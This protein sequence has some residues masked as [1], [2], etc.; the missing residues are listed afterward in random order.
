[1]MNA[2]FLTALL[3]VAF[4]TVSYAQMNFGIRAGAA[5]NDV[6]A[7]E[8]LDAITPEFKNVTTYNISL[9]SEYE[10]GDYFSIQPELSYNTK[11]FRIKETA[12]IELWN[13]PLPVGI[14]AVSKFSYLEVPLLFKGRVGNDKVKAYA[15]AGP[16]VG[17]A[18]DGD[19]E[20][21]GRVFFDIK[22]FETD[23][24]LDAVGYE[25]FEVS[26]I[27]GAGVEFLTNSG[28][29]FLDARYQ[30]GFTQLYDIPVFNEKI[31]NRGTSVN[32][33]YVMSF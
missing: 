31:K 29:I 26:G 4:S 5:F 22:L 8:G 7:T 25:R 6:V 13:I 9:I 1:M 10:I 28:K 19:L 24:D 33:G 32:V 27:V 17:Y 23:I 21:Y 12:D 3:F 30:H 2:K 15:M 16:A 11:G 14:E 18:V 20:T